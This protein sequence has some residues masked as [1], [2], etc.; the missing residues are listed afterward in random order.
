MIKFY[1]FLLCFA[2]LCFA[3]LC[4]VLFCFFLLSFMKWEIDWPPCFSIAVD[5][6]WPMLWWR[7]GTKEEERRLDCLLSIL[8][9]FNWATFFGS[10]FF[11]PS[12]NEKS[13]SPKEK[14]FLSQKSIVGNGITKYHSTQFGF[15]FQWN[16]FYLVLCLLLSW[17]L[18][19]LWLLWLREKES[20]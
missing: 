13:W 3:L 11:P 10:C 4:F 8:S 18:W 16:F 14:R 12:V 6:R 15:F 17:L 1:L 5:K 20:R 7:E 9:I 2:L 19:L